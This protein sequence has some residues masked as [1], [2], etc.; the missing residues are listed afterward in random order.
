MNLVDSSINKQLKKY[1]YWSA[2]ANA[3][4]R[5]IMSEQFFFADI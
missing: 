1:L 4:L 3:H 2:K 5:I